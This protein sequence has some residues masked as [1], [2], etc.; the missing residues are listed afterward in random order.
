VRGSV[1][2]LRSAVENVVR[3]AVRYTAPGTVVEVSL[4]WRMDTAIL[5]VRD[6]GPG[7]PESELAHIFEPFYRVSEARE[8][9]SGGRGRGLSVAD[10]TVKLHGGSIYAENLAD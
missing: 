6:R 7:V 1:E 10:R 8:R 4:R 2:L 9:S 3:N 5:N